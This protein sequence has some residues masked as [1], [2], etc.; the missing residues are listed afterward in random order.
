MT[1]YALMVRAKNGKT[2]KQVLNA[3]NAKDA[4]DRA[5]RLCR[6][7]PRQNLLQ[8]IVASVDIKKEELQ[9]VR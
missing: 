1:E 2:I 4:V 8:I 6:L 3:T 7:L 9:S 5:E